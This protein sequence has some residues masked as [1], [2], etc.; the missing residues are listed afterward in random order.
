MELLEGTIRTSFRICLNRLSVADARWKSAAEGFI[1]DGN[2]IFSTEG[3]RSH[4]HG[5]RAAAAR[6]H[7]SELTATRLTRLAIN[8]SPRVV[9][10]T[11]SSAC[12]HSPSSHHPA[13]VAV[14]ARRVPLSR[15]PP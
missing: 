8:P 6:P 9:G 14:A 5:Y 1:A 13:P 10:A 4:C 12:G 3:L 11:Q 2:H 15:K 7:P